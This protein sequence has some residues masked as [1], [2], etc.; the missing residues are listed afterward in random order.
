VENTILISAIIPTYNN[1]TRLRNALQSL[2]DQTLSPDKYEIIVVDN[3]STDRTRAVVEECKLNAQ[4]CLVY[5]YEPQVGLSRARNTGTRLARGRWVAYMDDDAVASP[6]WL[7]TIV[8][9]FNTYPEAAAVGGKVLGDWQ[10]RRP[11]WFDQDFDITVSVVD[12]GPE[13]KW[14]R[15][16]EWMCGTNY[17][18]QR[19]VLWKMNGHDP[20]LGR[21]GR[22]RLGEEEVDLQIRMEK[23]GLKVIYNP[24]VCVRHYIPHSRM[25]RRY[26]LQQQY[27]GGRTRYLMHRK[28]ARKVDRLIQVLYLIARTPRS[29]SLVIWH[30]IRNEEKEQLIRLGQV[31]FTFG[32]LRQMCLGNRGFE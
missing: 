32:Y 15:F 3:G 20:E 19:D 31:W 14:L 17:A 21:R 28:H 26:F 2:F 27:W 30:S 16:P 23:V 8:E 12:W 9:T 10:A 6:D 22:L 24:R 11:A 25:T 5:E 4:V 29:L 7:Q 18:V 13:L 1:A